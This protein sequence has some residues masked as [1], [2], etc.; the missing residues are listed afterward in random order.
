MRNFFSMAGAD[1]P[2]MAGSGVS[3]FPLEDRGWEGAPSFEM[4]LRRARLGLLVGL[5][6]IVMVFISFTSAYIVRQGLPTLEPNTNTLVRDWFSIRLPGLLFLNTLVLLISSGSMELAR[7][8][9]LRGVQLNRDSGAF[10][11]GA[12]VLLGLGFLIGQWTVWRRLEA[13]GFYI[14]SNPSSSFVYLLTG[15]HAVHVLGG[16]LGLLVAC[17]AVFLRRPAESRVVVVDIAAWY[18]HFMAVLWVYIF[19]LLKF[20]R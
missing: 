17:G 16:V 11:L 20:A 4:R 2:R 14:S 7:R 1:V 15:A 5:V 10:W 13:D 18:W 8:Q 19:S 3:P 6:G 12:T 9:A